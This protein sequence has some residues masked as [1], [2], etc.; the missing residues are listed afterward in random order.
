[1]LEL[2]QNDAINPRVHPPARRAPDAARRS[3]ACR[4][5]TRDD[6]APGRDRR[7]PHAP[8]RA[9]GRAR[10]RRSGTGRSSSSSSGIEDVAEA[11]RP[12]LEQRARAGQAAPRRTSTR[13][14]VLAGFDPASRRTPGTRSRPARCASPRCSSKIYALGVHG[15]R[16][17][18]PLHAT[19][20][21]TATT[22]SRC[23]T[24][25]EALDDPLELPDDEQEFGLW[26]LRRKLLE[27]D[28]RRGATSRAGR[29]S[30]IVSG[31]ARTS[32]ATRR[33]GRRR[34][35]AASSASTSSPRCS[36][37]RASRSRPA[38]AVSAS[39]SPAAG[40]TPLDVEHAAGRAVPLRRGDRGAVDAAAAAR[41]RGRREAERARP[42]N[43]GRAGGRAR[44]LLRAARALGAVRVRS[45]R[46]SAAA[47]DRLVQEARTRRRGSRTFRREFA[48]F[49]RRCRS[50][51]STSPSTSRAATGTEEERGER[52]A[53]GS[54]VAAAPRRCGATRTP[55]LTPW[56]DDSGQPPQVTW[57]P[58]PTGGAFAALLGLAGT[59]LLGE[60]SVDGRRSRLARAARAARPPSAATRNRWNAPVPTV[61]PSLGPHADAGAAALRR[62]AQ[63]LRDAPT[64]TASR[65]SARSRSPSRWTGVLLVE[66]AGRV[67]L[68]GRRADRRRASRP[69]SRPR[70][71]H[72]WRLTLRRGQKRWILLNHDWPGEE[73]P[74]AES[75]P[76]DLRRGVYRAHGRARAAA[77]RP[78]SARRTFARAT[79]ASSSSTRAPTATASSSRSRIER[80]FRDRVDEPLDD[81]HRPAGDAAE[82][83]LRERYTSSLRDIR[84]T[85][86]RAFKAVL[87][88]HRFG[89]SARA[90]ARRSPVRARLHARPR[91]RPFAGH[92]RTSATGAGGLRH[93]PRVVR[94]QPPAGRATPTARPRPP[95]TSASSP[96]RSARRRCSTGGSGS[97]TT[98]RCAARRAGRASGPPGGCSTRR[99]SASPTIPPSC[100]ATSASTS[101]TPRSSSPTST[102]RR[103]RDHVGDLEAERWAIRAWRGREV[104]ARA[105]APLLPALDRRRAAGALGR[106]RPRR[107]PGRR[108]REPDARS[109]R[110]AASRTATRAATRTSQRLNDGLRERARAA[111][112]A[113][114]CGMDRVALPFAPGHFAR[115]AARS[116]ATC[117]CR[118]SR[119]G[120]A[121]ARAG[122]RRRSARCRRSSSARGS[123]SS[124]AS[125]SRRR[126]SS[127]GTG[128]SRPS[129]TGSAASEREV[130]RENWIEWDELRRGA[131]GRGVPLPGERAARGDAHAS[132][133]RA[134]S[135]GGR[136]GGRPR[137]RASLPLQAARA[138]ADARC[139]TR[140]AARG[141]RP[142][143]HARARRPPVVARA[144]RRAASAPTAANGDGERRRRRRR[145]RRG[146]G[147]GRQRPARP[148]G[149]GER[150]RRPTSSACRSG[151]RRP[152]G[153]APASC[154]SR[155]PA[156]RRR[157][158][159]VRPCELR[160]RTAC[161]ADCGCAP[162]AARRRVLLLAAS[163]RATSIRTS[164][165]DAGRRRRRDV[166]PDE[167]VGLASTRAAP[168]PA[169]LAV[170]ADGA[171]H[172]CRV[173]NGEFEQP[174]RSTRASRSTRR[175]AA[176]RGPAARLHGPHRR[177][178]AL[179]G[180]RRRRP[181]GYARPDAPGFRYDL[182]TDSAVVLPLVVAPPAA[183]PAPI[184]GGL[185]A[186][187]YFA[188]FCPGAPVEPLSLFS[189]ALTVAGALRAH[190]RFEAALKWYELVVR[191]AR[192]ATTPGR[193]AGAGRR[194]PR[195]GGTDGRPDD[196]TAA[197]DRRRRRAR[198]PSP[199]SPVAS[200]AQRRRRR[201]ATTTRAARASRVDDDVA[202]DRASSC[203]TSRRC[204]SGATR[205]CAAT[206]RR[207]PAGAT[208]SSTRSA[209]VLGERPRDGLR[210]G[211]PRTPPTVA[212]FVPRPAP[213]NP[214]LLA[215]YDRTADRLALIHALP[216]RPPAA[217]RRA[218]TSTCRTSATTRCRDGW[219]STAELRLRVRRLLPRPA[220]TPTAS[221]FLR[222]AGARARRRRAQR[223]APQLLAAYEK[224]DAEYLA[225]AARDARAP[226]ARARAR[227]PPEPVARGRLAGAGAAE[228]EGERPDPA[229]LLPDAD[230][231]R[232][233]RRRGRLRG[234][235][236]ASRLASRTAGNV[237]EA[238]AQ[239]MGMVPDFS[240]GVAGIAG[241]PLQ[242]NQL[243]LG[244]KLAAGVRDR[245]ADPE[246]ARRDRRARRAA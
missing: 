18:L 188:Y 236:P 97:S 160:A 47:V 144:A 122:S 39:P 81:G 216:Q 148:R 89:L 202:R 48:R 131:Q 151:S 137:I 189:V 217:Q 31:A 186:Y 17:P 53:R 196:P 125:S 19:R 121:S 213:L 182:A 120:S 117:C 173:H 132:P 212:A 14:R 129:T 7:R 187:P 152:S 149:D 113:Y 171:P 54:R 116:R 191:P 62:G 79:P 94:L 201:G 228:D 133:C 232:P 142:A 29:G 49:Y 190:C 41:R 69:T 181:A 146:L 27:V 162:R 84:R 73:A 199:R 222:P 61:I 235:R 110:T 224:G 37:G 169:A 25:N 167:I 22:R 60:F 211:R 109:C 104:A 70:E 246:R 43:A 83:F 111:L 16:G 175:A 71:D 57:E 82:S 102:P 145:R 46:T 77:S 153:S 231:E 218:R 50:S 158:A 219:Q 96:A 90:A 20:T 85:Y 138:G 103:L 2:F 193:S 161:C 44:A 32:S 223:S 9:L 140:A 24:E 163:T 197:A 215:L 198:R 147:R 134:G 139:S 8:A 237:S 35:A 209:R 65:S 244:N 176:G 164:D 86:Q 95:T 99:R 28:A 115:E 88:A 184:P 123:G 243:P 221:P 154:A 42:L 101:G 126:S 5:P 229:A 68:R 87:F 80:L 52:Q 172:W 230:R 233:Q 245:R 179:R 36:S 11:L 10:R 166:P 98:T 168:G 205:C 72:R 210:P 185:D 242:F 59:G 128:G 206:R 241:S 118:T 238:I 214:R 141:P 78:S 58:Q 106:R 170:R 226:A 127:C 105:R 12:E 67:P 114:L 220:A 203:A 6:E 34:P 177:L 55:G 183:A 51:P 33:R 157:L 159:A 136:T 192:S 165:V 23:Q 200:G 240:I 135:S 124:R 76:L 225:V 74:A 208:S 64:S 194:Q 112:V 45:S 38:A 174:R 56:E 195:N 239:A 1:M 119:P 204:C 30:R 3:S 156:S 40:T 26:A 100:C 234:A 227:D 91:R 15:R 178:A 92:A 108:Q 143:R 75:E 150:S 13:S 21:S 63:R 107:A 155:R 93:P 180:E 130:Y 207:L 66:E 4:S